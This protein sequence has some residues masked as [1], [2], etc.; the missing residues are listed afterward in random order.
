MRN[1]YDILQQTDAE[2]AIRKA[3]VEVEK[4]GTSVWLS[5]AVE[6]LEAAFRL[7]V[8]HDIKTKEGK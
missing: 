6:K 8:A 7:S 1:P 2:K 4:Q 5:D 3:I